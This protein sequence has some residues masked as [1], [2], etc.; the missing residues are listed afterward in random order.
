M[1]RRGATCLVCETTVPLSQVRA[2]AQAG[3]LGSQ[4][5][6]VVAEGERGRTYVEATDAQVDASQVPVPQDAPLGSLPHNPR[7]VTTPNYA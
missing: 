7:A 5:V 2:Q 4:L 6:C 1:T 3:G